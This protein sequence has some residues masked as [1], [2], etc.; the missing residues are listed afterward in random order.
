MKLWRV[1]NT[2]DLV[3][4]KF[5]TEVIDSGPLTIGRNLLHKAKWL[6]EKKL[7]PAKGTCF[8]DSDNPAAACRAATEKQ[9]HE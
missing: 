4:L 8:A 3:E 1:T 9:H 6:N 5:G 7:I 2:A